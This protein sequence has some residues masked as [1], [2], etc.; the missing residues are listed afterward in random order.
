M[1]Q[2]QF[3][4]FGNSNRLIEVSVGVLCEELGWEIKRAGSLT[5]TRDDLEKGAEPDR[6]YPRSEE[7]WGNCYYPC[8]SGL[9]AT[10]N[11]WWETVK[12]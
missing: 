3:L 10:K 12:L 7:E 11:F 4:L 8:F 5:L 6:V 1:P 2:S 9:G